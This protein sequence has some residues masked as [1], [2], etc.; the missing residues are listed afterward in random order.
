MNAAVRGTSAGGNNRPCPRRQAI[1]PITCKDR[2]KGFLV[3]AEGCPVTL[4]LILFIGD[5][6]LNDQDEGRKLAF[7][8]EIKRRHELFAIF[9]GEKRIMKFDLGN[10]GKRAED[11][12]FEARLRCRRH[13][14]GVSVTAET[15]RDPQ[16][17]DCGD[18]SSARVGTTEAQR[19]IRHEWVLRSARLYR[20]AAQHVTKFL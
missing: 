7:G 13:G 19:G 3:R 2:L 18:W 20:K 15:R 10:P 8:R 6:T 16:Y 5:G 12:I 14:Y 11:E 9:V 17:V 4:F 1:D